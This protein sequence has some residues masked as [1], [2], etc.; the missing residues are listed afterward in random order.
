MHSNPG[1]RRRT[2]KKQKNAQRSTKRIVLFGYD[3]FG[4]PRP[5]PIHLPDSDDE[6]NSLHAPRLSNHSSST[7]TFDSDAAPLDS[8]VIDSIS[9]STLAVALRERE[10]EERRLKAERRA[11]WRER[12]EMRRMA[13]M[14]E[15]SFARGSNRD[16]FE[17]FQGSGD[18]VLASDRGA[19]SEYGPFVQAPPSV[20]TA[21][22]TRDGSL[23]P[24]DDADLDGEAYAQTRRDHGTS[25]ESRSRSDSRS[26]TSASQSS[27]TLPQA[28][29][30]ARRTETPRIKS[31][32]AS[33]LRLN[34]NPNPSSSRS[35][36]SR[37]NTSQSASLPSPA[38]ISTSFPD[39][40]LSINSDA[41][42]DTEF[43]GSQGLTLND[44]PSP[45]EGDGDGTFD[46][47]RGTFPSAGIGRE[48]G[49]GGSQVG[50]GMLA[51]RSA[52]V[53]ARRGDD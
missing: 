13:K 28:P 17:G 38:S 4:R 2:K 18:G 47:L 24:G 7:L 22:T 45:A 50:K 14:L 42:A 34:P 19:G 30:V 8:S 27:Y 31:K 36:A 46:K 10:E 16:E 1:R 39:V 5:P 41:D 44:F 53:L 26:R 3:L 23:H 6:N 43:D 9:T 25:A 51:A 40:V 32:S 33:V 11:R 35:A 48:V 20:S 49:Q 15:E 21:T 29:Y 52:A 12:K 37:S